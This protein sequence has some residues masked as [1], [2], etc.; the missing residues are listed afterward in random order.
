MNSDIRE[1]ALY[2]EVENLYRA[3]RLPGTGQIS[4][5]S[6]LH[7]S[8]D[9]QYAAFS[10][11]IVDRLEDVAATR[12]AMTHL[13]T[14]DT[15]ALTFGPHGDRHPKFSPVGRQLAFLSDRQ[16]PWMFM[17]QRTNVVLHIVSAQ[18]VLR[19]QL[20]IGIDVSGADRREHAA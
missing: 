19:T 18:H 11:T 15:R 9:A 8:P 3:L 4:D 2:K 16:Q 17:I 7:V 1:T 12:I 10:A 5:A 20:L 13:A 6:E 14:G